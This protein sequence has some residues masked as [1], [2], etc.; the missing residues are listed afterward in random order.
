MLLQRLSEYLDRPGVPPQLPPLY[1]QQPIRYIIE[2][3]GA[4]DQAGPPIDTADPAIASARRGTRRPAPLVQR[5]SAVKPLLLADN[6]EYT[7]GLARPESRPQRVAMCHAAYLD[8][9]RAC[10]ETTREAAV[11][12]VGTYL[13]RGDGYLPDDL[14]RGALITFRVDGQMVIDLPTVQAFWA[15]YNDPAA[16]SAPVMEC[17]VCGRARP[18]L[19]RLQAKVKGV[20]GG[21]TS[22]TSLISANSEAFESYGQPASL[23]APT[24]A[25]CGQRF[26][27]ALNELLADPERRVV[28]GG[29]AFVAWTRDPVTF[30]FTTALAQPSAEMVT[31]LFRSVSGG[32]PPPA[33]DETAFYGLV[34]SG[35]GGRTVVRDWIDTTV[36]QAKGNLLSWFRRQR[37]VGVFGE[38]PRPLGLYALAAA[39]VRDPRKDLGPAVPRALLHA[40]LTGSV[41]PWDVLYQAVRRNRAEQAVDRP[42]AGL[43][44]LVLASQDN[45]IGEDSMVELDIGH[46]NAG[47]QCGRLLAVL[48]EVQ[49]QAMPGVK[50]TIV[51]RFFGTA[52]T[53]PASVFG[54]LLRGAQP[55]LAKLE[56]DR[57]GAY[58]A[59]QHRLED[60]QSQITAFPRI[61]NLQEQG[62]FALGYYHQRAAD[63]SAAQA[64][65]M[66]RRGESAV[67]ADPASPKEEESLP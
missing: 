61:L 60:V 56:R 65:A 40:S 67:T 31:D 43:I 21:Q 32:G 54:R 42:R 53:A 15:A 12:A 2:L 22:G 38:E 17:I 66:R 44:K 58:I 4:G 27:R 16:R 18:V 28:L 11:A 3:D 25:E 30:S 46:P 50:A 45:T 37:I 13:K 52:S 62:L 29:M 19:E 1:G 20:P 23:V 55:H 64:A 14:D 26:T 7:F 8:L 6:A 51:D 33:V 35:S 9:L 47:Y 34:L 63:R 49:R 41:V 48:E 57:E 10:E 36:G 39:T 59:L 24:C 5:A